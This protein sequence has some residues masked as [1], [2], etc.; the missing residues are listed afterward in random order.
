MGKHDDCFV[1]VPLN[2]HPH[3]EARNVASSWPWLSSIAINDEHERTLDGA[4]YLDMNLMRYTFDETL[5][6]ITTRNKPHNHDWDEYILFV[7]TDPTNPLDLGAE[8]EIWLDDEQYIV[9]KTTAL[10]VPKMTYHLPMYVRKLDR[11]FV[12]ITTGTTLRY[13]H[14]GFSPNPRWDGFEEMDLTEAIAP[15]PNK[16]C[17]WVDI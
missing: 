4:F 10:F 11:P 17:V 3:P 12:W 13:N 2:V 16:K 15:K 9:T 7:G 6:D 5:D 1:T 8:V 14:L